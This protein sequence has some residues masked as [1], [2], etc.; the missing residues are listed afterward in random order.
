MCRLPLLIFPAPNL[1]SCGKDWGTSDRISEFFLP[2]TCPMNPWQRRI[3][4]LPAKI[5]TDLIYIIPRDHADPRDLRDPREMHSPYFENTDS[6]LR[7]RSIALRVIFFI[8]S[9]E[10]PP[11]PREEHQS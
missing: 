1:S 4:C 2:Q 8:D 11:M 5:F 6:F 3:S 10:S 9:P 7:R